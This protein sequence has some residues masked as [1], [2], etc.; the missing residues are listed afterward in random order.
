MKR[1]LPC[2]ALTLMFQPGA[3]AQ[4]L[5]S[6]IS[7]SGKIPVDIRGDNISYKGGLA[8]WDENV[9]ISYD[10]LVIYCDHA[11]FNQ[12]SRDV[13]IQGNVRIYRSGQ[14]LTGERAVY[15]VD[16]K[17]ITAADFR[18]DIVPFCFAAAS[19]STLG[20][21]GYLVKDAVFTTSDNS[22][23]DYQ[24]RAKKARVYPNDRVV[25]TNLKL[26][27][28][29]TP[30]FWVPYFYQ[31]LDRERGFLITPGFSNLWGQFLLSQYSLPIGDAQGKFRADY[32]SK[33]GLG[34]GFDAQWSDEQTME[35]R[36]RGKGAKTEPDAEPETRQNIKGS[37]RGNWGRFR[38]YYID[39]SAPGTNRTAQNREPIDPAR[40]RVSLQDRRYLTEDIYA[41][42]DINK[43]SDARFLQ[44]FQPGLARVNPNPDNVVSV[45]KW[46]ENYTATFLGRMNL[47]EKYFD[48]TERLPEGALEIKRQ[49]FFGTGLF[50][51]GET[52]AGFYRRNFA[53]DSLVSDYDTFRADTF[54]QLSYPKTYFGWLSLVP[55]AGVR[56]TFYKDGGRFVKE[57][58]E[59]D[60]KTLTQTSFEKEGSVFR[61]V[62]N[63]GIETSYK[64]SRA[65]EQVQS[66]AWGLD[67][68]RHVLQ[69]YSNLSFV[70]SNTDP[71]ELPQFDRINRSTQLPPVDFPQ[72]NT[73]DSIDNWSIL[74]LGMRNRLQTRRDNATL[75]WLE[76]D[77]FFDVNLDRPDFLGDLTADTGTFSNVFNR[78]RWQPLPWVR[79][80]LDSQLPLFDKGFTEVNTQAN[81]FATRNLSFQI[82]HRYIEGNS[83]SQTDPKTGTQKEVAIIGDGNDLI[84][85]AHV[86]VNDHWALSFRDYY[87]FEEGRL[88]TQRYEIHRDLSSWIASLGVLVADNRSGD[89][90]QREF[91]MLLTF[92]L[93]DLPDVRIP[94][95]LDPEGFVGGG[96]GKNR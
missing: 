33:R 53:E 81:F 59:R 8:S 13:L 42:T 38:S 61:P 3:Q 12:E 7:S 24:A 26:Y 86:R 34:L 20:Q 77:T 68:L 87:A 1:L 92:T 17:Q 83:R 85:G 46:D 31:S 55:R 35:R 16:T 25:F 54:H 91:G 56:G 2:L 90:G 95:N 65:F 58:I 67:G 73:I 57:D 6:D 60:G 72:F 10:D 4:F 62:L 79:L 43:L 50:Y 96:A 9:V 37:N 93:K 41:T 80:S 78:L 15:N 74:R 66:R 23:P 52:S 76:L 71:S 28:G 75:N 11:Q 22:K 89:K 47:N 36:A 5:P 27:I 63:A 64:I 29:R 32:L 82:G 45:T 70:Y 39:D 18:G 51:D 19:V 94:L 69:P 84:F 49:P 88:Q 14:L 40:Y 21:E 48:Q 30:V 44:D